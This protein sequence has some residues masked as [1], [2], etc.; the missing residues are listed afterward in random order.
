MHESAFAKCIVSILRS[1]FTSS[2]SIHSILTPSISA[3]EKP[4]SSPNS[5][6]L[7][8][9]RQE[10]S[11]PKSITVCSFPFS[12]SPAGLSLPL[13]SSRTL[14]VS[15]GTANGIACTPGLTECSVALARSQMDL[16]ELSIASST[17]LSLE[18]LAFSSTELITSAKVW[19]SSSDA[20]HRSLDVGASDIETSFS[21]VRLLS[22]AALFNGSCL[23]CFT[24]CPSSIK[25]SSSTL[26]QSFRKD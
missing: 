19:C 4:H 8:Y 10:Y 15:D 1:F 20:L 12:N 17:F 24:S 2:L 5:S 21:N 6:S 25:P 22:S 26:S 18:S 13:R 16:L 9:L 7:S 23:T 14:S 3:Y 11:L